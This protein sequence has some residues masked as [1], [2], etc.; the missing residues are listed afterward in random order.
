MMFNRRISVALCMMLFG[1]AA[2]AAQNGVLIKSETMHAK[3][4]SSSAIVGSLAKGSTVNVIAKQSGWIQ[5][6]SGKAQGWVRILSVRTSAAYTGSAAS[7]IAG[8]AQMATGKRQPG[9]IVAT[10]GVRGLSEEDLKAAHFSEAGIKE[11]AGYKLSAASAQSFARQGKLVKQS[12]A[13]FPDP[14]ANNE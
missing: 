9:Q 3:P 10:A 7:D 1:S 2:A 6:S 5:I 12:V 14:N 13:Y 8:V 4:A 11:L